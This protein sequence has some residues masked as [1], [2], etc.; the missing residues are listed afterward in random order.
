MVEGLTENAAHIM[1]VRKPQKA[2]TREEEAPFQVIAPPLRAS[3]RP[4]RA[5]LAFISN[6]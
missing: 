5:L 4:L 6:L 1:A 2:E 3:P